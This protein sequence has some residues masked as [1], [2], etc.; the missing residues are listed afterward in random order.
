MESR[1]IIMSIVEY[2]EEFIEGNTN[3]SFSYWKLLKELNENDNKSE[4]K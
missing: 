2:L 3:M 1:I 4:N